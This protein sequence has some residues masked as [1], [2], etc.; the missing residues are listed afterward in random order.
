MF[1]NLSTEVPVSVKKERKVF[2]GICCFLN[3]EFGH[4]LVLLLEPQSEYG[5]DRYDDLGLHLVGG[6]KH[7]F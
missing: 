4:F 6:L 7:G 2:L 3:E 1:I 5:L